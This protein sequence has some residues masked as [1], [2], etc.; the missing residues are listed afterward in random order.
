ML[1]AE[2]SETACAVVYEKDWIDRYGRMINITYKSA[3][4]FMVTQDPSRY[5]VLYEPLNPCMYILYKGPGSSDCFV[6]TVT[7]SLACGWP[8]S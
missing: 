3:I 4:L 6:V 1:I 5:E 2:V 7:I 8:Y